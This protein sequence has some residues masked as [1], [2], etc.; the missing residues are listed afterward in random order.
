[1][2][3]TKLRAQ[4][5][6]LRR[7]NVAV[8]LLC[9]WAPLAH[10]GGIH[11]C[12]DASGAVSYQGVPC[13]LPPTADTDKKADAPAPPREAVSGPQQGEAWFLALAV[14]FKK[15]CDQSVPGFR[16]KSSAAWAGW[17]T[18]N[19]RE[20]AR[21]EQTPL[22]K[23][24]MRQ[25]A[26]KGHGPLAEPRLM[27]RCNEWIEEIERAGLPPDPKYATPQKTWDAFLAALRRNDQ[28]GA[29]ACLTGNARAKLVPV[30]ERLADGNLK[31][32]AD[33]FVSIHPSASYGPFQ[34]FFITRSDGMAGIATFENKG[35]E[36]RIAEM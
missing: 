15:A 20:I 8:L 1:M 2:G 24:T 33:S 17:R 26:A 34:E 6:I 12:V 10:A 21:L 36:W 28:K 30:I 32:M 18:R 25:A 29:A 9:A 23:E 11:K 22:F 35:G 5:R 4:Q 19:A 16:E 13:Q 14:I 27:E 31:K 3:L 7:V